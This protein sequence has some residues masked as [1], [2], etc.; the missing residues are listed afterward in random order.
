MENQ[1]I[2]NKIIEYIDQ[3]IDEEL[4]LEHL[5]KKFHYSKFHLVRLFDKEQGKTIHQYIKEKRLSRAAEA[6]SEEVRPITDIAYE[7]HYNSPQA[8]TQA[9]YKVYEC[10]PRA[11]RK[12]KHTMASMT[13]YGY[14]H[15]QEKGIAA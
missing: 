11:Y 5:S 1:K 2:V 8:F 13:F 9:F 10:S 7:A 4:S 3:N 6:L 14:Y 15:L 12:R